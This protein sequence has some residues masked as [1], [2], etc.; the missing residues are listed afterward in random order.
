[1]EGFPVGVVLAA[2]VLVG[3]GG[4]RGDTASEVED[5]LRKKRGGEPFLLEEEPGR[6][7]KF[8]GRQQEESKEQTSLVAPGTWSRPLVAGSEEGKWRGSLA[9]DIGIWIC[10]TW[11]GDVDGISRGGSWSTKRR[12]QNDH[13]CE[14]ISRL[15]ES[16][17]GPI[18]KSLFFPLALFSSASSR[19]SWAPSA[20]SVL[21]CPIFSTF[22]CP[23]LG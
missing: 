10:M 19:P 17:S 4:S 18:P 15:A 23:F 13:F 8:S 1:M 22:F 20:F 21:Q 14:Q 11:V 3:D 5:G 12:Q 16:S 7:G 2:W 6:W 9:G